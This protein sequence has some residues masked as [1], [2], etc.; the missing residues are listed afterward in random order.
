MIAALGFFFVLCA[1]D[2]AIGYTD[3]R[4][5]HEAGRYSHSANA[6]GTGVC[7]TPRRPIAFTPSPLARPAALGAASRA[8]SASAPV[9]R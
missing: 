3:R 9:A 7:E 2:K 4:G 6:F 5:E 8:H 1:F